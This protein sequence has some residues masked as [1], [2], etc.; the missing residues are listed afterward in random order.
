MVDC[1]VCPAPDVAVARGGELFQFYAGVCPELER[2]GEVP[3]KIEAIYAA[4]NPTR[5][6]Y[7]EASKQYEFTD[8]LN[9]DARLAQLENEQH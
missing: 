9:E 7:F 5:V 3:L 4:G 6:Y 1:G 2:R 8:R